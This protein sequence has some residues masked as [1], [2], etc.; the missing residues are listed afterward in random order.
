MF[1][2]CTLKVSFKARQCA[3]NPYLHYSIYDLV[4]EIPEQDPS[5][6]GQ[7]V[8]CNQLLTMIQQTKNQGQPIYE[9]FMR[10]LIKSLYAE[11]EY[12]MAQL[13]A[14]LCKS[15]NTQLTVSSF[16][17]SCNTICEGVLYNPNEDPSEGSRIFSLTNCGTTCCQSQSSWCIGSNNLPQIIESFPFNSTPTPDCSLNQ[18]VLSDCK[19]W[20]PISTNE[21]PIPGTTPSTSCC[22]LWLDFSTCFPFCN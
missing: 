16:V 7:F 2:S 13:Y 12:A 3:P 6:I 9:S 8:C 11:A 17:G 14:P 18:P 21:P 15:G 10:E 22:I 20:P 19:Y 4:F 1:P 5:C